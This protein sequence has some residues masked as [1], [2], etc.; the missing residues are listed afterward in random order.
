MVKVSWHRLACKSV[1]S[2]Q[3]KRD[4]KMDGINGFAEK[5][6]SRPG[7][8]SAAPRRHAKDRRAGDPSRASF[9]TN[10]NCATTNALLL[11]NTFPAWKMGVRS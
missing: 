9:K 8:P 10:S 11:T 7:S 5:L 6:F 2:V 3:E 4:E 1:M